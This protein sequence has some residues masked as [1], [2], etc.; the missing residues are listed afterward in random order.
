MIMNRFTLNALLPG[1]ICNPIKKYFV[2]SR[3][4]VHGVML[5]ASTLA[6]AIVLSG[7]GAQNDRPAPVVTEQAVDHWRASKMIGVPVL[8]RS[9]ETIGF[10]REVLVDRAGHAQVV[11]V[12]VGG[13][14]GFGRKDVGLSFNAVKWVSH[15]DVEAKNARDAIMGHPA[16]AVVS[17]TKAQVRD[18]PHFSYATPTTPRP[19]RPPNSLG[20]SVGDL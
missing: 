4:L 1:T 5:A 9:G 11:V 17:L 18:S 10:I 6:A 14:L 3:F 13:F 2:T 16:Y 15:E 12:G 20:G 7:A 19:R 8:D